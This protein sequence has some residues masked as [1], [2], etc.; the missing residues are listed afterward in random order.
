MIWIKA[1]NTETNYRTRLKFPLSP[2]MNSESDRVHTYMDMIVR[3]CI[4]VWDKQVLNWSF[5]KSPRYCI[6]LETRETVGL[7][8]FCWGQCGASQGPP[9]GPR[10][11]CHRGFISCEGHT[12]AKRVFVFLMVLRQGADYRFPKLV[13]S[14]QGNLPHDWFARANKAVG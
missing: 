11:P 7:S 6:S 3:I 1:E 5:K 2:Q 4:S 13:N 14:L 10:L 9:V 8:V 12:H